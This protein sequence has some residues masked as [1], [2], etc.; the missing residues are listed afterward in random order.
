MTSENFLNSTSWIHCEYIYICKIQF[1]K[2]SFKE[3]WCFFPSS[4]LKSFQ[5]FFSCHVLSTSFPIILGQWWMVWKCQTFSIS[6][7]FSVRNHW[8]LYA[9]FYMEFFSISNVPKDF[10]YL[11]F[12]S[13]SHYICNLLH[14][15]KVCSFY[16]F[17]G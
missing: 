2:E 9:N 13:G 15:S 10:G 4:M 17:M 11:S 8:P 3:V 6:L 14:I 12:S 1:P 7:D 16:I 5:I